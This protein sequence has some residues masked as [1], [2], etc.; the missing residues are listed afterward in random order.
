MAPIAK[1]DLIAYLNP[2]IPPDK[3]TNSTPLDARARAPRRVKDR[4]EIRQMSLFSPET[5]AAE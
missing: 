1:G 2:I 4:K 3:E 5:D